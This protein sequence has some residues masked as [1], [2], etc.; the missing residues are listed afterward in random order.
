MFLTDYQSELESYLAQAAELLGG[1]ARP[2]RLDWALQTTLDKE[3][4]LEDRR[5][6]GG[7]PP[8]LWMDRSKRG[9]FMQSGVELRRWDTPDGT[10]R[11]VR[12][13]IPCGDSPVES[14]WAVRRDEVRRFYRAVRRHIRS[15][16]QDPAPILPEEDLKR[17]W[18]NT[19][20]FLRRG[21]DQMARYGVTPKRGVLLLGEP[22]NGKTMA[23]RWLAAECQR[24]GLEW[25]T[26]SAETFEDARINRSVPSLFCLDSPGI[27]LFDD[28]DSALRDRAN[29]GETDRQAT[30][31]SELDGVDQ[32]SG[33]VFLFTTNSALHEL[34]PAMRRPG[35]IDVVIRFP[36]PAAPLRRRL[37]RERWHEDI[38]GGID[39]PQAVA[40]TDGFSFAEVE[41]AKKL[42][43]LRHVETG[44]WDWPWVRAEMEARREA[45]RSPRPIGFRPGTNG[46]RERM[47][48]EG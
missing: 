20:G 14:F 28:F 37:I 5:G 35:R 43:V 17:L 4:R 1:A 11:V 48:I 8:V 12:V 30:F 23:C 47:K 7:S 3:L 27:I 29:H 16:R 39:L 38:L 34:D 18:D 46:H 45:Q 42:L 40:D 36:S 33:V 6:L 15:E 13:L 24:H 44:A 41:E 9:H 10:I 32:K 2:V 26:V 22:G 21:Q 31:L 19:V 25:Q